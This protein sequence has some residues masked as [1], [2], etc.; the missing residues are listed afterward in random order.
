MDQKSESEDKIWSRRKSE[1][2]IRKNGK[3]AFR[4]GGADERFTVSDCWRWAHSDILEN[5]TRGV[6]AEFLVAHALK[7][8]NKLRREW[9]AFDCRTENGCKVEVKSAAYAQSWP[10]EKRSAISFDIAPRSVTWDPETNTY[11]RF[12]TPKR[13]ADVYVFC[14]LGQPCDPCPDP[15]DLDQWRFYVL[16]RETLDCECPVQKNI[17]LNPLKRIVCQNTE[18]TETTYRELACVI[19]EVASTVLPTKYPDSDDR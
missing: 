14:L 8:T 13:I 17:A 12:K 6:V 9:G 10:Q 16:A 11:C 5:T 3:E 18:R 4:L 2:K 15:M 19:E 7:Q 1:S